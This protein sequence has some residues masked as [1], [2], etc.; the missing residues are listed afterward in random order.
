MRSR[1]TK[2]CISTSILSIV[3]LLSA[4]GD[5]ASDPNAGGG[6]AGLR[7]SSVTVGGHSCGVTTQGNGWCWGSRGWGD[8]TPTAVGTSITFQSVHAGPV[9]ACG[10]ST[11]DLVYCWGD[12]WDG[13]LGDG[14][15]QSSSTPVLV[16]GQ[17]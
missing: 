9:H 14:T 2:G 13:K 7:F 6:P 5:S 16:F 8:A 4:C 1:A 12:N 10:V 15:F 3:T 11:D 17:Q